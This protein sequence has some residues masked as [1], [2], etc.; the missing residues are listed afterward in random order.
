M[1]TEKGILQTLLINGFVLTVFLFLF[2]VTVFAQDESVAQQTD[3]P[4][5]TEEKTNAVLQPVWTSYKEIKIG[6]TAGEVKDKLGKAKIEDKD[7]FYYEISDDEA[8]QIVLDADEKVRLISLIY[9]GKETNAPKFEEVFGTDI[10]AEPAEDGRIYKLV[11]YPEAG[12]WVA[13]SR[14]AGDKPVIT[15]TMQKIG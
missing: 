11:N 8:A 1:R 2:T 7:G 6:M 5:V 13:Y 9:M 14:T 15:V 4:K 10:T 12:Y 3:A